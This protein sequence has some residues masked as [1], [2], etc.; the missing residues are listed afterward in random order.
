MSTTRRGGSIQNQ[1]KQ[2]YDTAVVSG[3]TQVSYPLYKGRRIYKLPLTPSERE[4]MVSGFFHYDM[5]TGGTSKFSSVNLRGF[6]SSYVC[7]GCTGVVQNECKTKKGLSHIGLTPLI[8][9]VRQEGFE[10]PTYGFVVR[11]SIQLSHWRG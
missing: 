8:L 7:K 10:P 1:H 11:C 2:W 6:S 5:T 4:G 3:A 9:L